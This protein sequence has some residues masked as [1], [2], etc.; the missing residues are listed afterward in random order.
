MTERTAP[1]ERH[2][3]TASLEGE[4]LLFTAMVPVMKKEEEPASA[5]VGG[6]R[7]GLYAQLDLIE[8]GDTA[9]T[10]TYGMSRLVGETQ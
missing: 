10:T 1:V 7:I 2:A 3:I 5:L 8:E 4:T 6:D 9:P